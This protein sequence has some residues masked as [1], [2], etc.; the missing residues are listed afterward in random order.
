M[1]RL[2][3]ILTFIPWI[4]YFY[5]ETKTNLKII[6]NNKDDNNYLKNN[7]IDIFPITNMILYGILI[8]FSIYYKDSSSIF[9]VRIML[10]AAINL[11]LF[12]NTIS[13]K[14]YVLIMDNKSETIPIK[15]IFISLLPVLFYLISKQ[16]MATYYIMM[17]FNILNFFLIKILGLPKNEK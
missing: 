10:F 14:D 7:L 17:G 13:K 9:L 4:I 16:Q 6:K 12:F 8:F 15:F 2:F 11:Y 1:E 5:S 3:V